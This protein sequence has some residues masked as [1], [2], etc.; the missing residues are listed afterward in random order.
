MGLFDG[1]NS[2]FCSHFEGEKP[3]AHLFQALL[4]SVELQLLPRQ[5]EVC[6]TLQEKPLQVDEGLDFAYERPRA[7]KNIE[8]N[9]GTN[10]KN[11]WKIVNKP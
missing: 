5:R 7:R 10:R 3:R 2:Y 4:P 1:Q 9:Q 6:A 8:K 11:S